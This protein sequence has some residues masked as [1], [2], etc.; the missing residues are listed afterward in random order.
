MYIERD[1]K[2]ILIYGSIFGIIWFTIFYTLM[3]FNQQ[4]NPIDNFNT[5]QIMIF[6][7]LAILTFILIGSFYSLKKEITAQQKH[8]ETLQKTITNGEQYV[9]I[10]Y[11]K[12]GLYSLIVASVLG[13]I[14]FLYLYSIFI[15]Q[16]R[17]NYDMQNLETVSAM[18]FV[19]LV[20]FIVILLASFFTL[21]KRI[22]APL[23]YKF[24]ACPRCSSNDIHKVEY[25]WW[26]GLIGPALVHQVRCKK[27]GKTYDG[28]TG[29]NITK[30]MSIYVVIIIIIFTVLV[31]LR[32]IL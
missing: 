8:L 1:A 30:R 2:I 16:P 26:G 28:V 12:S 27:C 29:T 5:I 23:Y 19:F 10:P 6:G 21:M 4:T 7:I 25:S 15:L 31:L 22:R 17:E 20:I 3:V 24:K 11:N 13:I 32:Y 18:I 14:A 9:R